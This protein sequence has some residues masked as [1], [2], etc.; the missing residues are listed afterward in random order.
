MSVHTSPFG[1]HSAEVIANKS[2]K[3]FT[4]TQGDKGVS[5]DTSPDQIVEQSRSERTARNEPVQIL[6]PQS[7]TSSFYNGYCSPFSPDMGRDTGVTTGRS[8]SP[9]HEISKRSHS[10]CRTSRTS[11]PTNSTRTPSPRNNSA[12]DSP[13]R[14]SQEDCTEENCLNLFHQHNINKSPRSNYSDWGKSSSRSLS[15][16][17]TPTRNVTSRDSVMTSR[18]SVMTSRDSVMTSRDSVMTSR[19]SVM[20][21]RDSGVISR[22]P[23]PTKDAGLDRLSQAIRNMDNFYNVG[24]D[25]EETLTGLGESVNVTELDK[26]NMLL[27]S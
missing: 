13:R 8:H 11:S 10:P 2:N 23:S 14:H 7:R 3:I 1:K 27:G 5:R 19:D 20:T 16:T 21:S 15:R 4:V 22:T 6:R 18:D 26:A 12:P 17:P 24:L 9:Q 25:G